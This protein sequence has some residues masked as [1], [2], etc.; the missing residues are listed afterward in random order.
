[1]I[2]NLKNLNRYIR[3]RKF[4]METVSSAVVLIQPGAYMCTI[5]LRDAYYHVPIHQKSQKFLRFAV[6]SPW[7]EE[8]HYQYKALPFGIS[9]APRTFTK[10]MIE[11]IAFLR[12]KGILVIPYLDDLLLVAGSKQEL[13]HH[14]DFT[15]RILQQLGWIINLE[16]SKL[17]PSTE[18]VFLGTLLNSIQ[19]MS[20]L[21]PEK[22]TRLMQHVV[23]FQK[24]KS[25]HDKGSHEDTGP[26]DIFDTMC[27]VEPKSH[28]SPSKLDI[29]GL[30]QRSPTSKSKDPDSGSGQEIPGV[31][32]RYFQ[33][34][35][36]DIVASLASDKYPD[37]RKSV[38]MGSGHSRHSRS[39]SMGVLNQ[40]PVLELPRTESCSRDFKSKCSKPEG[41]ARKNLFRQHHHGGLSPSSGGYQEPRSPQSFRQDIHLGRNQH[42]LPLSY[43]SK[44]RNESN[45]GLSQ[46]SDNRP[47]RVVSKREHLFK[48]HTKM[49]TTSNRSVCHQ[50]KHKSS[51]FLLSA[52]RYSGLPKGCLQPVLERTANVCLSSYTSHSVRVI[53]KIREDQAKVILIVPWWPKRNWFPWLGKMALEEP[54]MLEP[55]NHLLFQG[56]VYHPHPQALRLSAWILKGDC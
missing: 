7:G 43:P 2:C 41:K 42:P 48:S 28:Q 5:D 22:A 10:I 6:R 50:Q 39:G 29:G 34:G 46:S 40:I 18:V 54:V 45:S 20:F 56:P 27:T 17:N 21:P 3:Y 51:S 44:G 55:L 1:M 15:M 13:I 35:K 19:Q 37:G 4:K 33:P 31:V 52:S 25:L 24:K 12:R 16:K 53:Q 26:Y 47:Q 11:V 38:R 23:M 36:R 30:G 49:G 32:D 9:S 8:V 14:R